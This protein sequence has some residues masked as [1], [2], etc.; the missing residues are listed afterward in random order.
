MIVRFFYG[1]IKMYQLK[2]HRHLRF[3]AAVLLLMVLAGIPAGV[4]AQ[5]VTKTDIKQYNIAPGP[6]GSA[7]EQFTR[8]AGIN[9]FYDEA[10]MDGAGTKG[11]Q[12]SYPVAQGL[13]ALLDGTGIIALEGSG[14]WILKPKA[15]PVSS[16]Q[17]TG[18]SDQTN[19][20]ETNSSQ[21]NIEVPAI[22]VS[23][24][25]EKEIVSLEQINRNLASDVSDLFDGT[26]SVVV[27]GGSRNA[28]RIYLRGIE[29]TN[30]NMTIDGARQGRA[31]FQHHGSVGGLDPS[32]LKQVEVQTMGSA[33]QGPGALGGSISFETL[34]AQDLLLPGK[35]SGARLKTGYNSVDDA[36]LG[37][38]EVYTV[39]KDHFGLLAHVSGANRDD[40]E[41]GDGRDVLNTAG[42]DRDYL[43]KVSMLDWDDHSLRL[44][45]QK[46]TATGNS[47]WGGTGSD[48]GEASDTESAVEQEMERSSYTLDHRYSPKTN[49]LI[50]WKFNLYSNE[51]SLEN[52]DAGNTVDTTE[53]GGSAKNTFFF[54]LGTTRHHLT[55]AM[56][57]FK[58]DG[59]YDNGSEETTNSSDNFGLALQERM[60]FGRFSLSMGARFD[61]YSSEYGSETVSGNEISPNING[62]IEIITGL[63]VFGGYSEA[64]RGSSIIPIQWLSLIEDDVEINNGNPVE[65]EESNT[66][67][68]GVK[69]ATS[70]LFLP[71]DRLSAGVTYF[72]TRLTNTIEVESGGRMGQPITAIYNNPDTL[73]SKGYE[74]NLAWSI[75]QFRTR[76]AFSSF[77]TEDGDGNPAGVIRRKT[78]ATGDQ[79]IWDLKWNPKP[80]LTFGYTLTYVADLTKV[81]EG[82]NERPGYVL[83]AIQAS[84]QPEAIEGLTLSLAVDN[85]FDKDYCDQT[86]IEGD[87]GAISE[88]GRDIRLA[89]TYQF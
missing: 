86:S 29:S 11:L 50:D 60:D 63:S 44:S 71:E 30:L 12:G 61:D 3:G 88:P 13:E 31:L 4:F 48:I 81:P 19:A 36:I 73:T 47:N 7:L 22:V 79:L 66:R 75:K 57:Y 42:D 55:A 23:G 5:T 43:F 28:Q 80:N 2:S 17:A 82:D 15:D 51:N 39:L 77:E 20:L 70:G 38:V 35:T 53:Y 24:N 65:P 69:Y 21:K 18:A 74:V 16:T 46:N 87:Y 78:A 25:R 41:N 32:M 67:Q 84:W 33:D 54:E 6:L 68:A 14:G 26:P 56:D 58:E 8:R 62:E 45:A 83:H 9:I 64:V 37:S 40:Y 10:L 34:D 49:P 85:L 52:I 27:G 59:S 72:N 76:L 89:V 1:L